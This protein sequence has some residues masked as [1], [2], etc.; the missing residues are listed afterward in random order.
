MKVIIS[1]GGT[2]GHIFPAVSIADELTKRVPHVEILFVGANNRM[3]ME[4]VPQAGYNIIG[5]P[6]SG[7]E[8]KLSLQN[9][10]TMCNIVKSLHKARKIIK[11]FKP[12][13]AVGVG[14]YASGPM[15]Y[16]AQK[17]GIPT[18]I[19]EQ[20]SYAGVTNKL[21]A[22]RVKKVCVAYDGME[23]FFNPQTIV[24]T[25]N[26]VRP[27]IQN[28]NCSVQESL[29]FFGLQAH[30]P[31]ILIVGGS[32]GARTINHSVAANIQTIAKVGVQVIWQTGKT[33]YEEAKRIAQ[34]YPNIKVFDFIK[35]MDYAYTAATIIISRAG[36]GTISELCIV[37]KPCVFVPSPNVTEDHQTKNAQALVAKQAAVMIPDSEAIQKLFDVTLALLNNTQKMNELAAQIKQLAIPNAAEKIVDEILKIVSK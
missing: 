10:K 28:M 30:V 8:R 12:D 33:Y 7:F 9:V 4:K 37:G 21:L 2:G 19:Q 26:P 14:G 23:R 35:Q 5:L 18:I 31:T 3:E 29:D 16:A 32:L 22:K 36:A 34:S 15:L 1:G 20:N 27:A 11:D 25:G 13:I 6:I 17:H 24:F